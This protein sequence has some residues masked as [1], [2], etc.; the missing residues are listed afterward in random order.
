[1]CFTDPCDENDDVTSGHVKIGICDMLS[2][3]FPCI[4]FILNRR[5][6]LKPW[7]GPQMNFFCH[8]VVKTQYWVQYSDPVQYP[9]QKGN[10]VT[11]DN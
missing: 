7:N 3:V 9:H 10:S 4:R 2:V 8:M 5:L 11:C 6:L 1:M